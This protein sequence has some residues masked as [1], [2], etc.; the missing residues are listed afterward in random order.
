[1]HA[2]KRQGDRE[3]MTPRFTLILSPEWMED[4]WPDLLDSRTVIVGRRCFGPAGTDKVLRQQR[5]FYDI[6]KD[7]GLCNRGLLDSWPCLVAGCF[8]AQMFLPYRGPRTCVTHVNV[9]VGFFH[10]LW[11][12]VLCLTLCPRASVHVFD[13]F[14]H[15]VCL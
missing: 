12:A 8:L 7:F 6:E 4:G 3:C 13:D 11:R 10:V 15:V 2:S 9:L 1:M 5:W 14:P